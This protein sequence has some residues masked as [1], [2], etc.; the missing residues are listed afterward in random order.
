MRR[1]DKILPVSSSTDDAGHDF[2][3]SFLLGRLGYKSAR[4][5]EWAA[6]RLAAAAGPAE[7]E[8]AAARASREGNDDV[9]RELIPVLCAAPP[10]LFEKVADVSGHLLRSGREEAGKNLLLRLLPRA[11]GDAARLSLLEPLVQTGP[12]QRLLELRSICGRPELFTG[13]QALWDERGSGGLRDVLVQLCPREGRLGVHWALGVGSLWGDD[14][15]ERWEG[16]AA[17]LPGA[18]ERDAGRASGAS[19]ERLPEEFERLAALERQ[20]RWDCPAFA[21]PPL[22]GALERVRGAALKCAES[23]Q[24]LSNA[25]RWGAA[26]IPEDKKDLEVMLW[27]A[28]DAGRSLEDVRRRLLQTHDAWEAAKIVLE[29]P[30]APMDGDGL[31]AAVADDKVLEELISSAPSALARERALR[32]LARRRG[33]QAAPVL[34]SFLDKEREPE[35]R[36]AS[37]ESLAALGPAVLEQVE[38]L[39]DSN[40]PPARLLELFARFPGERAS[41]M[42]AARAG[43]LFERLPQED[44]AGALASCGGLAAAEALADAYRSGEPLLARALATVNELHGR[45]PL[46]LQQAQRDL[47]L[48]GKRESRLIKRLRSVRDLDQLLS[49]AGD[50]PFAVALRCRRCR[51]EYHYDVERV[52]VATDFMEDKGPSAACVSFDRLIVCKR[53]AALEDYE[54]GLRT[55]V[56]LAAEFARLDML[57]ADDSEDRQDEPHAA[58]RLVL[59]KALSAG[60]REFGCQG[61]ALRHL[62]DALRQ[63][64]EDAAIHKRLGNCYRRGG[65]GEQSRQCYERALSLDSREMEA[66]FNLGQI[67]LEARSWQLAHRHLR[68]TLESSRNPSFPAEQRRQLARAALDGLLEIQHR[69]GLRAFPDLAASSLRASS[70]ESAVRRESLDPDSDEDVDRV[71][72]LFA[73]QG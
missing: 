17:F 30:L 62:L 12:A 28:L 27:G 41:R 52:M 7:F 64:P 35:L 43:R 10:S 21:A 36:E 34:A 51:Y 9:L 40:E 68:L 59:V 56:L 5:R 25:L 16:L 2:P 20:A 50:A 54:L 14:A 60:G 47:K 45:A 39:L 38:T 18:A 3:S 42:L 46:I 57:R 65:L 61:A 48:E 70:H 44:V 31:D 24:E 6:S 13:L 32:M 37:F 55:V 58:G 29:S 19:L 15:S 33:L 4:V 8:A 49:A 1:C 66:H 63:T 11:E 71:I 26:Q 53:C 67:H 22:G 69:A 23:F 72:E 73:R